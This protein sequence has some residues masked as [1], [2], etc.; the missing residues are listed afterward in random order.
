LVGKFVIGTVSLIAS[1]S[2][3]LVKGRFTQSKF[4][5]QA[6]EGFLLRKEVRFYPAWVSL[7]SQ[8]VIGS[9]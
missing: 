1:V 4:S 2:K 3:L 8:Q 7:L 5:E 9:E 6:N